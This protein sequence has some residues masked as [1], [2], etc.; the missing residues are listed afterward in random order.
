MRICNLAHLI[1]L[2]HLL[3][4]RTVDRTVAKLISLQKLYCTKPEIVCSCT[5]LKTDHTLKCF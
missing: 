5:T 3:Q 2:N 1:V 4:T